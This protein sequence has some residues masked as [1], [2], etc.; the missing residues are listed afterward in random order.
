MGLAV[1]ERRINP[2]FQKS[3]LIFEITANREIDMGTVIHTLSAQRQFS[4]NPVVNT[5]SQAPKWDL[6]IA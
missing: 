2:I 4:A 5:F 6:E 1:G 3:A